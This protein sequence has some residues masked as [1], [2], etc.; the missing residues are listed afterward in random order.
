M[1][2]PFAEKFRPE[3]L[4]DFIGQK[5]LIGENAPI[6][7]FIEQKH[8][9]S[10][11]FWGNPGTGK[12]TLARIISKEMNML[13]TEISATNSG[14][15]ELKDIVKKASL[16]KNILLF[17]DEI[18]RFNKLQQDILL[19]S[20]EK[21][22]LVMIGATTENPAFS[23][24]KAILSRCLVFHFEP[25]SSE[26]IFEGLKKIKEKENLKTST[27]TLKKI[28]FFCGGD[29]RKALNYL[30]A[31]EV[32]GEDAFEEFK[33]NPVYDKHSDEHFNHASALQKSLRGSDADA[34]IYYIAKMLEAGEDPE[35]IARRM[36]VC[37]AEDIGNEDPFA[38]VL[39][40]AVLYAVKNLG[41]PEARI[42][43]AQLAI[44]LAKAEKSN[45]TIVSIDNAINDIR[46]GL[47]FDVPDHLKD[48]HYK[49][50]DKISGAKGYIYSH[51][52]PFEKQEFLPKQLKNKR[53]VK[54][55]EITNLS[56]EI[57]EKIMNKL[58]TLD[59][60]RI[61]LE[62]LSISLNIEKWKMKKALRYLIKSGKIKITRDWILHIKK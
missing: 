41:L 38:T 35:F 50:A 39:A 59:G 47:I 48:T 44:Y 52:N 21:G 22:D 53:Y 12:T 5:H 14:A 40:A 16:S 49:D 15:K 20:I 33:S 2:K 11:I 62:D 6:K 13:F 19:P 34:A 23:V 30:E 27:E 42:H 29:F 61:N 51:S 8:I 58:K 18:H 54:H 24:N 46:N 60:E 1:K 28:S 57:E 25:L 56:K 36:F 17:V 3:K 10:M 26:E 43:L 7:K 9:Q 45:E 55:S 4:E 32:T 37:A 31:I